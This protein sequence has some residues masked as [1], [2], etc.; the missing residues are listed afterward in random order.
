LA[1]E[2]LFPD[3]RPVDPAA[4]YA[5]LGLTD[6]GQPGRP[7][8]I[9]N[10]ICS[11]DGRATLEGRTERLSTETDR[12]LLGELR[13]QVDAV[14]AGTRT[15][16]I[17]RYGP[18]ARTQERR[19]RRRRQGLEPVPLAVT[20]TRTMELPI[21]SP[22]F[23]DPDSQIVVL[24]NSDREPAPS[25]AAVTVER[26]PGAELELGAALE[27]LRSGHGVRSLLLEGG[28]T[29]LAAMISAGVVDELFLAV[30]PTLAGGGQAPTILE[31]AAL[32]EPVELT[33]LSAMREGSYL[34]LRYALGADGSGPG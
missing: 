30:A 33:L 11:A 8:V 19:E 6:L 9:A 27:R 26:V 12:R 23:Q 14:M 16:A 15:I 22:L 5:D 29:L 17:E 4:A 31:G 3:R 32:A 7:Y 25:P 20:A 18:L 1:L 28:P 34:F 2:Q 13:G 10:M 21:D 24:T